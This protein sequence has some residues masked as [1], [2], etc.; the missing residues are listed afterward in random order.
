MS[1]TLIINRLPAITWHH[2]KINDTAVS[3]GDTVDASCELQNASA[4]GRDLDFATSVTGSTN[5]VFAGITAKAYAEAAE[6]ETKLA[7]VKLGAKEAVYSGAVLNL[8]AGKNANLTVIMDVSGNAP[9]A[10]RTLMDAGENAVIKLVEVFR[11]GKEGTVIT[12]VGSETADTA[13]IKIYEIYLGEG[14]VYAS[15][16]TDLKGNESYVSVEAAYTTKADRIVD[17]NYVVNHYG[18]KTE[19]AIRLDGTLRDSAKKSF[20]AT[21]DFKTGAS[22]SV[23]DETENVLLLGDDIENKTIPLILCAEEDVKGTHGASIGELDPDVLFYFEQRGI[24]EEEAKDILAKSKIERLIREIDDEDI[25]S[26]AEE[27]IF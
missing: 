19:S 15:T 23:G 9:I 5:P 17:C 2:L 3:W 27:S 11:T 10:V 1:D 8:T 18:K 14:N 22:G 13:R 21:I 25:R 16:L 26:L 4:E 6:G 24:P 7:T 12:E 20:R